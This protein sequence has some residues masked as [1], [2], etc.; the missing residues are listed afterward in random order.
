MANT[1]RLK[2]TRQID[3]L[4]LLSGIL[5]LMYGFV[6]LMRR[7]TPIE[8]S[9]IS[10][11]PQQLF[12]STISIPSLELILPV[13][14]SDLRDG[15][16][17]ISDSAVSYLSSSP[18]PG[19]KGNSVLYGHNWPSLLGELDRIKPGDRIKVSG[20]G[21]EVNYLVYYV[22]TVSPSDVSIY[23][24]TTDYRLTLYTC[25]G[26]MDSKRLVVTALKEN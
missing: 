12:P 22:T 5:C 19:T 2:K 26:F 18:V 6:L 13:T 16:W 4:L 20:N 23:D 21:Q 11:S 25:S 10:D 17:E 24:D 7:H 3:Y 9:P 15:K 8:V 1:A 14:H